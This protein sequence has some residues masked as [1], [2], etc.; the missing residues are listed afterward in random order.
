[1]IKTKL[2][3]M[4]TAFAAASMLAFSLTGCGGSSSSSS[5]ETQAPAASSAETA[6][7][8]SSAAGS[9]SASSEIGA[10]ETKKFTLYGVNDLQISAAMMVA[11]K[12]GY[13][14]DEGLDVDTV[15]MNNV[16]EIAAIMA[17]GEATIA[18]ANN[19]STPSWVTNGAPT[20]IISPTVN[21]GGTQ[22]LLLR[23][24]I[25]IK[26]PKDLEGL[27][28]G[29]VSGST[30]YVC[31]INMCQ[32]TGIDPSKIKVST[33]QFADQLSALSSG[34]IDIMAVPEPWVTKAQ[35]QEGAT[36]LCSG[37]KSYIPGYE[38]D[39]TWCNLYSTLNAN[40]DW[41]K[42]NPNTVEHV[43]RAFAKATDFINDNRDEAVKICAEHIG[44]SE[45]DTKKIMSENV[46]KFGADDTYVETTKELEKFMEEN[47]ILPSGSSVPFE[48]YHDFT[49][50]KAA[51]PE[52]YTAAE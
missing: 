39:V 26:S 6:A 41:A 31:F 10:P 40:T 14:K 29:M 30:Q 32:A 18:C 37:T 13:F 47:N 23:K 20:T 16:P 2:R 52:A 12:E 49:Y 45:D 8:Q 21:M 9:S 22:C 24:G 11:E 50:L 7:S 44:M 25:E 3:K 35:E 4:L 46:Y 48:K 43:L 38:G 51:V 15:Y 5:A 36:L 27:T 33:L 1:M 42:E 28:M 34:D 19:Y 17:N